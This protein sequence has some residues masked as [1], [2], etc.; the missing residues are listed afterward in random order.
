MEQQ[1]L[2]K[3]PAD[4][5]RDGSTVATTKEPRGIRNNNPLNIEWHKETRWQGLAPMP[6]DGRF[7]RF[8]DMKYGFRAAF[9]VLR[10]YL[11]QPPIGYGLETI[12]QLIARWA[13]ST[14]NN[15]T[16]YAKTVS[17]RS[18]VSPMQRLSFSNKPQ[19]CRIVQAMAFVETGKTL[20]ISLIQDS[21][22]LARR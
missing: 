3:N 22:E 13:P 12:P 2:T 20:P 5:V 15:S 1:T 7:A 9:I 14:E 17:T 10:K 6:T 11:A 4:R 8:I 16:L 18:G 19:M 21:Y